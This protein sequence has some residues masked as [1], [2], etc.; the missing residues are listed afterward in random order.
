MVDL[1]GR[2]LHRGLNAVAGEA[3]K[4]LAAVLARARTVSHARFLVQ[5][6][7]PALIDK[8]GAAAT[9]LAADWY[10]EARAQADA[11]GAFSAE[12]IVAPSYA[13]G[14]ESLAGWAAS[15][16]DDLVTFQQLV[17]GGYTRR[18]IQYGRSTV[19]RAAVEDRGADGWMRQGDGDSCDF[20]RMLIGRGAV[21]GEASVR[22]ASHDHCGC[23]AV[24]K[25]KGHPKPVLLRADGT[26]ATTSSRADRRDDEQRRVSNERVRAWLESHPNTG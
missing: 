17:L 16:T 9:A 10:D 20:C 23:V 21:Y 24:P 25:F 4:E 5:E 7:L 8:Y 12:A 13:H 14:A 6:L 19:T 1:S 2:D 3:K 18:V 26:R 15:K 11:A 22:F